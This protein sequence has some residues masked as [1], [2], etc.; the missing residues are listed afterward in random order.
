MASR[1]RT[2]LKIGLWSGSI[3][4][5]LAVGLTFFPREYGITS[6]WE[7]LYITLRLFV[8]EHD[9][10]RFP[11][12]WPLVMI[13]FAAPVLTISAA[14]TAISYLLHV[15]PSIKSRMMANHVVICGIGRTGCLFVTSLKKHK[16]QAVGIDA[17]P[18]EVLEGLSE[19]HRTP[20]IQGDFLCRDILEKAGAGKAR[21]IVFASGSDIL[22]LEGAITAFEWLRTGKGPPQVIWAQIA[23]EP[24]ARTLRGVL[25]ATDRV[26][27]RIFDTYWMAAQKMIK[28]YF[29]AEVRQGVNEVNILG[30]GKFGRDL[31]EVLITDCSPEER[32]GIRVV[33]V[34]DKQRA[35]GALAAE[36][37]VADRVCFAQSAIQDLEMVDRQDRAFFICTDDD[38][39]NLTAA[40]GLVEKSGTVNHIFVR[41]GHW[42]I[43]AVAEHLNGRA[44]VHFINLKELVME[45]IDGLPGVFEPLDAKNER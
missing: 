35:V 33:D 29:P 22:N 1:Y 30:F 36:L 13:Y 24:L 18:V 10:P 9:L 31:L 42:P 34:A 27:I 4:S 6:F 14:G 41:M 5:I 16:I 19:L 23:N 26:H 43:S 15:S 40:I 12:F 37:N 2:R 45:A 25:R 11:T 44:Q 8:F 7:T 38:I 32:F 21:A 3:A 39:G 20:L 17:Q 28:T